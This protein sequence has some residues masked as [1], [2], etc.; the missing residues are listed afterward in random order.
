MASAETTIPT[1]TPDAEHEIDV[2]LVQRLLQAQ[3]SDLADLPIRLVD[4]GWD[5]VM[6]R[7]GEHLS[8]RLPRRTLAVKLLD[9]EQTWL[10][11]LATRLPLAVPAPVR[12]GQPT[13]E[14]PW[15]W[16]ILPWLPG[17]TADQQEPP[18]NQVK[19]WIGFLRALHGPAPDNAPQNPWRGVP[20]QQRASR[21]TAAM[22]ELHLKTN[23]VTPE[24]QRI[25]HQALEAPID[26][27]ATWLHGDL[28]PRNV[29]VQQGVISGV[30]DWGDITAGDY[31]TDLASIW[32][33]FSE[34]SSR[35][36]AIAEYAGLSEA[37]I[38]RAKGWAILFGVLLLQTGLVDH[39]PH[40]QIGARTLSRVLED[41]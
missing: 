2:A 28:H 25:W 11:Q 15:A 29:L 14:Y 35:Q 13:S 31:A 1:G 7:L 20:L 12:L 21:V 9:H 26:I 18:A 39:P 37:T 17:V 22:A 36:Q 3:H 5:N 16:S 32:M 27:P 4:S 41:Q 40:A 19:N 33:L 6:F 24:I 10:P 30:I 34:A 38:Q 23:W 8:V